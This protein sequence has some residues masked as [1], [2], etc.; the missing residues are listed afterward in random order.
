MDYF[1]HAPQTAAILERLAAE[2]PT[3]L[4]VMHGSAWR[5]DGARLLRE[6]SSA[7]AKG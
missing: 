6:L 4:A 7:L 2:R 3:T 1:A 5:G